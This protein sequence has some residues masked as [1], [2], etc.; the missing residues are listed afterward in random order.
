MCRGCR[1]KIKYQQPIAVSSW[2]R[3]SSDSALL[4][5]HLEPL[6]GQLI[7]CLSLKNSLL[8]LALLLLTLE[9][10]SEH[11]LLEL[12]SSSMRLLRWISHWVGL[13]SLR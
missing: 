4:L 5:H 7:V 1:R 6:G 9:S 8:L 11:L 2:R 13:G 10:V 12:E 3:A